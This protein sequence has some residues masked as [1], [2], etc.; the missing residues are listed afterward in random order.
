MALV[1]E[2]GT[3]YSNSNTYILTTDAD[4]YWTDRINAPWNALSTPTKTSY[5]LY[6]ADYMKQRYRGQ[7]NGFRRLNTQAMDWP[8]SWAIKPDIAGGYGPVPYYYGFSEIPTEVK[9]AQILLA[10]KLI[11][12]A[13][14][15]PDI[16]KED[17]P[18]KVKIGPIEI[19][20]KP[21]GSPIIKY[22]DVDMILDLLLVE[23][24]PSAQVVR[25]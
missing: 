17:D 9:T 6:A 11:G 19:D 16:S 14:L 22:R 7:W 4:A 8:R 12:Y 5:V 10:N 25:T 21:Y 1:L 2:D 13:S 18:L 15:A 20:Y 23:S 24:G 3:G